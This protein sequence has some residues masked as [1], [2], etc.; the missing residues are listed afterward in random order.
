[1]TFR[2]FSLP[3]KLERNSVKS[4]SIDGFTELF[5]ISVVIVH[6]LIF[7]VGFFVV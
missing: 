5:I 3:I 2:V 7:T 6:I 1:M 4:L